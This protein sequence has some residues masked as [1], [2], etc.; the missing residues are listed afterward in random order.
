MSYYPK[1]IREDSFDKIMKQCLKTYANQHEN[2]SEYCENF[3][4]EYLF[5]ISADEAQVDI[6]S[7]ILTIDDITAANHKKMV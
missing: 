4:F 6:Q 7:L 3:W 5:K 2:M 1:F